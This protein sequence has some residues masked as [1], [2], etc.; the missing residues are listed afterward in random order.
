MYKQKVF[1]GLNYKSDKANSEISYCPRCG[2]E[3]SYSTSEL[4]SKAWYCPN[5]DYVRP[6]L[7]FFADQIQIFPDSSTF[8]L[9]AN[10]KSMMINLPLPGIFNIYNATAAGAAASCLGINLETIKLG[11]ESYE[12]LFGRSEKISINSRTVIIQL[13]KNPAGATKSLVS[14]ANS[15]C[16]NVLI[17][18]NDNFADGRDVS[19]LW[20]ANFEVLYGM[21]ASFI[22]SGQRASDM[23]VRLK[24]AGIAENKISCVPSLASAFSIALDQ[25]QPNNTLWVL[26]TYTALLEM[27]RIIKR[28]DKTAA[29]K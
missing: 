19:W 23:A 12:T 7:D 17:A 14:L 4:S 6:Q 11:L 25:I 16:S 26:P 27:Q 20:D 28:Y 22:V 5:C 2:T 21:D 8:V 15:R 18:I 3:I 10:E 1:Y 9:N 24:Y 29:S 13:I